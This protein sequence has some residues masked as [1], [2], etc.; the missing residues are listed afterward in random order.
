MATDLT[1]VP[2]P[3]S[4]PQTDLTLDTIH[5]HIIIRSTKLNDPL[6]PVPLLPEQLVDL[7]VEVS[8]TKFTQSSYR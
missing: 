8:D 3:P 6:L 1:T 2:C 5:T 4:L 7:I